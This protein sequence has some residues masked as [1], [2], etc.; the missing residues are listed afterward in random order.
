MRPTGCDW[1]M[2][3]SG[4]L[5]RGPFC[6]SLCV[7][8]RC[9]SPSMSGDGDGYA[10]D[11]E[12]PQGGQKLKVD[13]AAPNVDESVPS[14]MSAA[15]MDLP[16]M[17]RMDTSVTPSSPA[18]HWAKNLTEFFGKVVQ[19]SGLQQK[20]S[21]KMLSSCTGMCSEAMVAEVLGNIS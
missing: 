16:T 19:K 20:R 10:S 17:S 9:L 4:K 18:H 12:Q 14:I 13:G 11:I 15:Q 7:V 8:A 21:I 5:R 6:L 3:M 2:R 1:V